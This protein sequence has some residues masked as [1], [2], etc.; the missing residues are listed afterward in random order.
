M[1]TR[2]SPTPTCVASIAGIYESQEET[3]SGQKVDF[4]LDC[5]SLD[6]GPAE[7]AHARLEKHN[8]SICTSVGNPQATYFLRQPLLEDRRVV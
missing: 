6:I 3:I 4:L 7:T 8:S 2:V 1:D 5:L